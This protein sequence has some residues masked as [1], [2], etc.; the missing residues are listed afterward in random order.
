MSAVYTDVWVSMGEENESEKK[1]K[2]LS[3]YQ[4][5]RQ[6]MDYALPNA[7]F[8]HCLPAQ[9]SKEVTAEIFRWSKFNCMATGRE[10]KTYH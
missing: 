4:V 5:N 7:V 1:T 6:V 9:R 10:Q 3:S 2:I 8:L